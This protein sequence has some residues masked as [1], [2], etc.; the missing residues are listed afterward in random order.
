MIAAP[1]VDRARS[2]TDVYAAA[3]ALKRSGKGWVGLCAF[4]AE[5]TPSFYVYPE[6]RFMCFGCGAHGS[7]I[8]FAMRTRNIGFQDAVRWLLDMPELPSRIQSQ[9]VTWRSEPPDDN[10]R[11][12][13][14]L[15]ECG[16]ITDRTAAHLYLWSRGISPRQ[17]GLLAHPA[18]YC[19]EV[20]KPL[21]AVVAPITDSR[22]KVCAIQ[23]IWVADRMQVSADSAPKDARATLQTRKKTLGRLGDGAVRL[24]PASQILGIAEGP[25]TSASAAQLFRMNVWATCGL[26]RLG[27]PAHWSTPKD[28]SE[29]RWVEER[30]PSVWIP[31]TVRQLMV[32]GDR[33]TIGE[34]V[35]KFAAAWWS[36]QGLPA[37]AVFPDAGFGD[38]A[39]MLIGARK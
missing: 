32:F 39:D 27:Y 16:P 3:V 30:A 26:S 35:A 7:A 31:K 11:V 17:P 12:Q 21:P 38:F 2:R 18:L 14:I 13:A 33:G 15:R 4:H 28:E 10:A 34:T 37:M 29:P 22:G 9:K 36:R 23:R 25:E 20:G 6:G 19:H 24:G 8:D 1:D 5:K